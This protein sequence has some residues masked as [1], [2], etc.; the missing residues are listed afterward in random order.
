MEFRMRKDVGRRVSAK[1]SQAEQDVDERAYWLSRSPEER[2]EAVGFM[3][4]QL[5][6]LQHGRDL[7]PMDKTVGHK[8]KRTHA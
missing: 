7:P 3:T 4:R 8:I 1:R 2:V 5:Y 6:F